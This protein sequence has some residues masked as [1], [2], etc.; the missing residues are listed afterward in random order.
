MTDKV[1]KNKSVLRWVILF[2]TCLMMIGNYYAYDIPAALHTQLKQ[3]MSQN[4]PENFE[5]Y[6]SL[7]YTV[8]SL[9][10]IVLPFFGGYFVDKLGVRLCLLVFTSCLLLGA[11]VFAIGLSSKNWFVIYVHLELICSSVL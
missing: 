7:L 6:F 11:S 5:T 1:E 10:N 4:N 3:R 2:L 9:P 8:Y